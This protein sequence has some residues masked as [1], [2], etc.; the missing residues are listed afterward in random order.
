VLEVFAAKLP[1]AVFVVVVVVVVVDPQLRSNDA[2]D[3]NKP[4]RKISLL[5]I[6]I[7]SN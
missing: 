2:A 1:V 5:D 7:P 4:D 6:D 3:T